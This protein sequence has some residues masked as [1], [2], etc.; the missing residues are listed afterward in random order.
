MSKDCP[1]IFIRYKVRKF[2]R[3]KNEVQDRSMN[4]ILNQFQNINGDAYYKFMSYVDK[5]IPKTDMHKFFRSV[6]ID[7]GIAAALNLK[8]TGTDKKYE[9]DFVYPK[10]VNNPKVFH[11]KYEGK[12]LLKMFQSCGNTAPFTVKNM[13]GKGE[14][15]KINTIEKNIFI[16]IENSYPFRIAVAHGR[17]IQ[18]YTDKKK[19]SKI[20]NKF[21][22]DFDRERGLCAELKGWFKKEHLIYIDIPNRPT[23]DTELYNND[24]MNDAAKK[25]TS[26]F[27]N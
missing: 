18:L 2:L 14:I 19:N 4:C 8:Y 12:T 6:V 13:R 22:E 3:M 27:F 1:A 20:Y 17:D 10:N 25:I 21:L 15:S 7:S 11:Y 16:L 24:L 9:A 26:G 23:E 5:N